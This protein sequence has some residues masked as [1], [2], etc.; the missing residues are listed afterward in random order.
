MAQANGPLVKSLQIITI[1]QRAVKAIP[2][3]NFRCQTTV[4]RYS[5]LYTVDKHRATLNQG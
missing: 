2:P 5:K 3:D 1:Y 4:F